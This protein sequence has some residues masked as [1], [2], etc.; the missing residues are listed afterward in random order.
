MEEGVVIVVVVVVVVEGR[1]TSPDSHA[2][3]HFFLLLPA[4]SSCVCLFIFCWWR[5]CGRRVSMER[6]RSDLNDRGG[7]SSAEPACVLGLGPECGEDRLPHSSSS[8]Y[9]HPLALALSRSLSLALS[10]RK[11]R[12]GGWGQ[13]STPFCF[14]RLSCFRP[15]Y[16]LTRVF[17]RAEGYM[18]LHGNRDIAHLRGH[19]SVLECFGVRYAKL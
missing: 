3:G 18:R 16:F 15:F 12:G 13:V 17:R 7:A 9:P 1:Q 19:Q 5:E 10:V 2:H 8:T 11:E 6:L 4:A 14:T